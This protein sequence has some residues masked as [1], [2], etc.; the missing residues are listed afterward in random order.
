M[1]KS[2]PGSEPR[3]HVPLAPHLFEILLALADRPR[4]G[5]RLI[6]EIRDR[7]EGRVE[8]ATSTLYA[9]IRSLERDGLI[10]DIGER[11]DEE[12]GGPPRRY[13][14]ITQLGHEVARQEAVRLQGVARRAKKRLLKGSL[15][16]AEGSR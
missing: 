9:A 7:T 14:R 8:L 2:R 13:Y 4:H 3:R 15:R 6:Q 16:A 11:L 5:Y 1:R 10:E 12:S